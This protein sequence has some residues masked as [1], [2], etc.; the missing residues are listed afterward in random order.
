MSAWRFR[1]EVYSLGV[2]KLNNS[3]K[4]SD[5][6]AL[7]YMIRVFQPNNLAEEL[8]MFS[9][10]L[11]NDL[12]LE[13]SAEVNALKLSLSRTVNLINTSISRIFKKYIVNESFWVEVDNF[14]IE[15]PPGLS[16][17]SKTL[18]ERIM[19]NSQNENGQLV[20][21]QLRV[22]I[23]TEKLKAINEEDEQKIV[24]LD[25]LE[26]VARNA[27]VDART[28]AKSNESEMTSYRKVAMILD[29][30]LNNS[31]IDLI[32][33]ETT[34]KASKVVAKDHENIYGDT[35]P[36]NRG[37]GRR[38]DLLLSSKNI[39]LS[40][41][42]WKRKKTAHEQLI[43]QQTKNIRMNK[44]ILSKLH[45]L[46][47]LERDAKHL[48]TMSMDWVGPKGYTF[49]VKKIADIYVAVYLKPLSM[50]EYLFQLPDFIATL[51]AL[52]SWSCHQIQLEEVVLPAAITKEGNE[53]FFDINANNTDDENNELKQRTGGGDKTQDN[54][55]EEELERF[56]SLEKKSEKLSK[57]AKEYIDST[58][59]IIA[60]QTRLVQVIEK[61]YGDNAF[62]NP[63]LAEYK[64]AIEALEK[65]S[66][67]N[68]DPA[69]QKAVMEPLARFV[70]YFPEVNE[71]VKRRNK[72][73]L[74]YDAQ[75]S[76]VRKL[77]DK[78]VE[79]PQRL[80]RAEQE[81]NLAR[82]MYENI[83]TILIN[84]LPKVVDLRVPYLDPVFEALVKSQLIFSQT[85]YEK[86]EG[87]RNY[88]PP[89]NENDRRVDDV[90][91]QMREL[92]ICG[93]F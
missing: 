5:K 2:K 53:L 3:L 33:G 61:L 58:R 89:E 26:T 87:M 77:I 54:E 85:G 93:N 4:D 41:N 72:K 56:K 25:I 6:E 55:F 31:S 57:H 43:T 73:L 13:N 21:K 46:P 66:K 1:H 27:I 62:T 12:N 38:I 7:A 60:S 14:S 81:A 11:I 91:Q 84:D 88:I 67:D 39:E 29:L 34:C 42:E 35:I 69:Y 86:L 48:Y 44:A 75:R 76:K 45:E 79:D 32:D 24:L 71:A 83:N 92:T 23:T 74:D 36:L 47:L 49:A 68:L 16:V 82:E 59:A 50:P 63:A 80:P 64:R 30:M 19:N 70:S 40:T 20:L 8:D 51:D 17:E 28:A 10:R 15:Q 90:L 52:Y 22:N 65:E 78:P 18:L 37:F 9:A